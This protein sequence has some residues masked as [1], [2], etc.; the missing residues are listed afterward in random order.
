MDR[1]TLISVVGPTAIGKTRLA[2]AIAQY[3]DTE[4][5]S[6]DSRQFYKE[7]TIGTAVPSKE[8]LETVT[9]HFIQHKSIFDEYSVGDFEKEALSLLER[10]FQSK[11][12]VVMVGG[13]G[14]YVDAVAKGLDKFPKIDPSV[15]TKL[16]TLLELHGL[17]ELQRKLKALDPTYAKK[18]DMEN[19]HRLVRALEVCLGTGKPY[20]TFLN[21][22]RPQRYFD[23]LTVGI[24]TDRET[25]YSRINRRLDQMIAGGLLEEA[26]SLEE[27]KALNALQTVGYKELFSYF[28]GKWD[29]PTAVLEIKKN[30]RRF[31]KRQLT[32]YRKKK[33]ILWIEYDVPTASVL[34]KIKNEI[35]YNQKNN[36]Q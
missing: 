16:N 20:S 17:T 1:K 19:P 25:I 33:D 6:A 34:E 30:T 22:A 29:L 10:L 21:K 31:A 5:L 13:S 2:I 11:N 8:E 12:V 18:V 23:V 4:I 9:H 26:R 27:H 32:W 15:R 36:G 7:M 35:A 24:T 3:F 14:L 28:E